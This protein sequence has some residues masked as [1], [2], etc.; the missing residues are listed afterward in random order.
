MKQKQMK[1][2]DN[3]AQLD[4]TKHQRF[5][6]MGTVILDTSKLLQ[7]RWKYNFYVHKLC[8]H[9]CCHSFGSLFFSSKGCPNTFVHIMNVQVIGVW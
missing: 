2:N 7:Q 3:K 1:Q 9:L 6:H 5:V 8:F 4:L